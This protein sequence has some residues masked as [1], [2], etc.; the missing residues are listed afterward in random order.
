M[1]A[2]SPSIHSLCCATTPNVKKC[3]PLCESIPRLLP[4]DEKQQD[5][6]THRKLTSEVPATAHEVR[7]GCE[8]RIN[9]HGAT[10]SYTDST[11][12]WMQQ[13]VDKRKASHRCKK[14]SIARLRGGSI[15]KNQQKRVSARMLPCRTC[16]RAQIVGSRLTS[17][18]IQAA[19]PYA[20]AK[21]LLSPS[22]A[23]DEPI[24]CPTR[25][26]TRQ[27]SGR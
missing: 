26:R 4:Q 15:L 2:S 17:Q 5:T 22:R 16:R 11:R 14:T 23:K 25:G 10:C 8:C 9:A 18:T 20:P 21:P 6:T 12:K 27:R 7:A 13:H 24:P 1:L 19:S 3:W